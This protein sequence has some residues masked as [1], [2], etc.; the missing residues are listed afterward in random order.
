MKEIDVR[1]K[2]DTYKIMPNEYSEGW[3]AREV[4]FWESLPRSDLDLSKN[5]RDGLDKTVEFTGA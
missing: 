4:G 3:N 5:A 1:F 2:P